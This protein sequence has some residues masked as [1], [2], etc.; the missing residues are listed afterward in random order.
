MLEPQDM[1]VGE[2]CLGASPVAAAPR[3]ELLPAAAPPGCPPAARLR[4]RARRGR[5]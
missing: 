3:G 1:T 2:P 4:T 5:R